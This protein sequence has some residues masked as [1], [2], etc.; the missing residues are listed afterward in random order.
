MYV[1]VNAL[2]EAATETIAGILRHATR[3]QTAL[4]ISYLLQAF[5]LWSIKSAFLAFFW[6]LGTNVKHQRPI[7][8]TVAVWNAIC[9]AIW[10]GTAT[11]KCVA[12]PVEVAIGAH[13]FLP[14]GMV[15]SNNLYSAVQQQCHGG[16]L[17]GFD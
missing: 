17:T 4:V 6:K 3:F 14:L 2:S 11:W 7:W 1:V 5:G 12:V 13:W 9:F 15:C 8:W 16:L 10:V